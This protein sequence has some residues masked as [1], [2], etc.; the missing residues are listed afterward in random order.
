MKIFSI[1][2]NSTLVSDLDAPANDSEALDYIYSANYALED[3]FL[4]KESILESYY[5]KD[6]EFLDSSVKITV[7]LYEQDK[8]YFL[9]KN[10]VIN[11]I[12]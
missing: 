2:E 11:I 4:D 10:K 3:S 12:K 1:K 9:E 5:I 8:S 7:G 6:V